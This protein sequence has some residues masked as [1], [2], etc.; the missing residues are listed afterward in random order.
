MLEEVEAGRAAQDLKMDLL[1]AVRYIIPAWDEV[2][3]TT[4]K[5]CW[6][7]TRILPADVVR[8]VPDDNMDD[9]N[10][11]PVLDDLA[12]DLRKLNLPDAMPLDEYLSHSD[13]EIV[14]AV[15]DED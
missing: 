3:T 6:A 4:I 7:H 14:N 2:T 13:E 10:T 5:N 1:Q 8:V 11:D 15:L 12:G 9:D